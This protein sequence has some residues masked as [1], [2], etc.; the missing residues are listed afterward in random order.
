MK[1]VGYIRVSSEEQ[2]KNFSLANQEEYIR[3]RASEQDCELVKVF[4]DEG[5]SAKTIERPGLILMLEFCRQKKNDVAAVFI[6][7]IDRLSRSTTDYLGLR[8][9]L[10]KYGIQIVSCTEPTGDKPENEF[11]ETILAAAANYDNAVKGLRSRDGMR[12]CLESG[13]PP[14]LPA[15]GYK[16]AQDEGGNRIIV[17]DPE[18]FVKVSK[19]WQEMLKGVYT[20]KDI[21]KMS[22]KIGLKGRRGGGVGTQFFSKMFRN[23]FYMGVIISRAFGRD[24][25]GDYELMVTPN[26]FVKVQ[27]ILDGRART[28]GL[29]QRRSNPDFPLRKFVLCA[30][31]GSSLTG[32]WTQGRSK[33]YPYYWCIKHRRSYPKK[34]IE[35]QFVELL[36]KIAP[37]P[38]FVDLF[39]EIFKEV[40][41]ERRQDLVGNTKRIEL[42][43]KALEEY[44]QALV[45]KNLKGIY[46]DELFKQ[47]IAR[48]QEEILVKKSSLSETKMEQ[49]DIETLTNFAKFFMTNLVRVWQIA[50]LEGRLK[51]QKAIFPEGLKY[52]ELG[53][54]TATLALPFNLIPTSTV[55][56][57]KVG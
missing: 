21:A 40:W 3:K 24:F 51:F 20:L 39:T 53:F 34:R 41:H 38:R 23:K 48:I 42:E 43:I 7:K 25:Q 28:A 44:K 11:I 27:L 14:H 56:K 46:S 13:R 9:H 30:K 49:V 50:D 1:A 18:R 47:Q 15:Y 5:E 31:C 54:Q 57:N 8:Q 55:S 33:K 4:R 6:Y 10:S 16:N 36:E 12:K 26:E 17:R 35:E 45:D 37:K 29:I 2:V 32:G 52:D 22:K 19:L